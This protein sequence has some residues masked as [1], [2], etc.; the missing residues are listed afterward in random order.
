[1]RTRARAANRSTCACPVARP[2]PHYRQARCEMRLERHSTSFAATRHLI[3]SPAPCRSSKILRV[4]C[5]VTSPRPMHATTR[6]L[7]APPDGVSAAA[8]AARPGLR[9]ASLSV[10]HPLL[11]APAPPRGADDDADDKPSSSSTASFTPR[12]QRQ[13]WRQGGDNI[14][15]SS[16]AGPRQTSGAHH[17]VG[18]PRQS[19]VKTRRAGSGGAAR[20]GRGG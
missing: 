1:V 20:R 19:R 14:S 5:R 7:H 18:E 6:L 16:S 12:R 13:V 10:A 15:S 9:A 17:D 11:L 8:A 4:D 3:I 2:S